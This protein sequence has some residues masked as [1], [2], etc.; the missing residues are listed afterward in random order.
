MDPVNC[1]G[2][3]ANGDIAQS[4][5][6]L[7]WWNWYGFVCSHDKLN[8]EWEVWNLIQTNTLNLLPHIAVTL[9]G[10][11][12]ICVY[13]PSFRLC[14]SHMWPFLPS[15]FLLENISNFLCQNWSCWESSQKT[16]FSH[17]FSSKIMS[18]L[19]VPLGSI[20]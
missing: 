15:L 14:S 9:V 7:D 13:P 12:D 18:L 8:K 6:Y 16:M 1:T 4:L 2:S 17:T 11:T 19:H 20:G 5:E 10:H 3:L